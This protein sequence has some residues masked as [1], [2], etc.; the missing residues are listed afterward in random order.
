M[1]RSEVS[2]WGRAMRNKKAAVTA[3]SWELAWPSQLSRDVLLLN[4]HNFSEHQHRTRSLCD[5]DGEK[6]RPLH[7]HD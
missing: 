6:T 4:K 1:S 3:V 5:Q 7:N 2:G